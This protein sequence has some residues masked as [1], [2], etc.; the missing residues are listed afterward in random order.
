MYRYKS[1]RECILIIDEYPNTMSALRDILTEA[2]YKVECVSCGKQALD[3]LL[4]YKFNMV[5]CSNCLPDA[6]PTR[7]CARIK[8]INPTLVVFLMR[9]MG[10]LD[11]I[12]SLKKFGVSEVLNKPINLDQ[13]INTI[14]RFN[15]MTN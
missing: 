13:L 8:K 1:V 15:C 14:N 9:D 12:T 6:E 7:L 2:G 11:T 4:D 5:L 10:D 3:L